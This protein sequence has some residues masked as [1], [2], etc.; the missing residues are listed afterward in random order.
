MLLT[1]CL[2]VVM[3]TCSHD[4]LAISESAQGNI[5]VYNVDS[6]GES[7]APVSVLTF[8]R[9]PVITLAYSL[10]LNCVVSADEMGVLEYWKADDYKAPTSITKFRLKVRHDCLVC[11]HINPLRHCKGVCVYLYVC[12]VILI[13]MS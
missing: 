5:N 11:V 1:E 8:H 9:A 4:Q 10:A 13:C 2:T 3:F 7:E 6:L 12:R